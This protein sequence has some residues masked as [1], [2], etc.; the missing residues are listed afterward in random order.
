M[1]TA[2]SHTAAAGGSIGTLILFIQY[3]IEISYLLPFLFFFLFLLGVYIGNQ[4]RNFLIA[5]LIST[6]S[7]S[8]INISIAK[9]NVVGVASDANFGLGRY[10]DPVDVDGHNKYIFNLVNLV[11]LNGRMYIIFPIAKDD[12]VHFN[13]HRVLHPTTILKHQ[14]IKNYMRLIR[15]DYLDDNGDLHL[16]MSVD[17]VP[18]DKLFG[19][20]IYTF[21]KIKSGK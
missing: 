1:S 4:N 7:Y 8:F 2:H 18:S 5:I 6:V 10:K 17:N 12:E 9:P 11:A 20:G 21:E 15:F 13:A 19:C 14:S 3:P 16:S